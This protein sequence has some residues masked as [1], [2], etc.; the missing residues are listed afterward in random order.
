MGPAAALIRH[1]LW[2]SKE[3]PPSPDSRPWTMD[4]DLSIWKRLVEAGFD[5]VE[6]NGAITMVRHLK[7]DP[8][9][10]RLTVFYWKSEE[11]FC[12]TPFL[13]ECVGLYHKR[14]AE[15]SDAPQPVAPGR[16]G[17]VRAGE[18]MFESWLKSGAVGRFSRLEV[19]GSDTVTGE[20]TG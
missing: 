11:G 15:I 6:L 7:T 12:A 17:P 9:P 19:P 20:P 5:P 16:R 18:I 3:P 8:A 1:H 4:R 2:Q 14:G 10:L 13:E